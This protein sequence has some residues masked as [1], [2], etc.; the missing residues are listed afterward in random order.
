MELHLEYT[1]AALM[2]AF[3]SLQFPEKGMTHE[4]HFRLAWAYLKTFDF[5]TAK[6]KVM[7][8][9]QHFDQQ[10]GDGTKYHATIT[11]A[12]MFIMAHRMKQYPHAGWAEFISNNQDLLQPLKV[13]LGKYYS[14]EVLFSAQAKIINQVPDKMPL[15]TTKSNN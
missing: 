11:V 10:I 14:D 13:L 5:E 8:G 15:P 4:A 2:K 1:D 7:D 9:I 12:Y 3:E 6:Q